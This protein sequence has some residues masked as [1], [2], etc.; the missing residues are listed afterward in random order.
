MTFVSAYSFP[1]PYNLRKPI[2]WIDHRKVWVMR[3]LTVEDTDKE[4]CTA[5]L[6]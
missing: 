5:Q 2:A 6:I 3:V 1:T 4:I